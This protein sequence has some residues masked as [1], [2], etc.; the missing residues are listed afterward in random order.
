MP[1]NF[2]HHRDTSGESSSLGLV[3][4]LAYRI[5][6]NSSTKRGNI[7]R[8]NSNPD[9][10]GGLWTRI[11]RETALV[12]YRGIFLHWQSGTS[13]PR[14]REM[15]I[16]VT[17]SDWL[18]AVW[19]AAIISVPKNQQQTIPRWNELKQRVISREVS[20]ECVKFLG[21]F[22]SRISVYI[23]HVFFPESPKTIPWSCLCFF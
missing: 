10:A 1:K 13:G 6:P 8:Q 11:C 14:A 15:E 20:L 3:Y 18:I 16:E 21:I 5:W 17:Q 4:A 22:A 23:S 7:S 9:N 19:F 2:T 12:L